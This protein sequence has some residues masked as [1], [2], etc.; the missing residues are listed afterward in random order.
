MGQFK[1]MV[2]METTEPSVILKLKKGGKVAPLH[3]D[4]DGHTNMKGDAFRAKYSEA[5]CEGDAPKKPSMA[6]RRK[7]MSGALLNSKKGGKAMKHDDAAQDRAMIKKAMA[8]KKF[9][10]G[11]K[12]TASMAKTTVKGNVGKFVNTDMETADR[13]T[14]AKGT[15]GVKNGNAGGYASGGTIKGNVGKFANTD[16]ETADRTTKAKGTGGVKNGNGGGYAGGGTIKGGSW[17]N[18]PADTAKAGKSGGTT[19]GVRNGNAGGYKTGG[20]AKKSYATGGNVVN[21][22]RAVAMPKKALS[23]PVSNSRQSGTF[24][25]GGKVKKF[26]MGGTTGA[27]VMATPMQSPMPAGY[28]S[29]APMPT[30]PAMATSPAPQFDSAQMDAMKQFMQSNGGKPAPILGGVPL[31][32]QQLPMGPN[33]SA[34]SQQDINQQAMMEAQKKAQMQSPMGGMRPP[35]GGSMGGMRGGFGG[36]GGGFG[37]M[38]PPMGGGFGGMRPQMGGGM[39]PPPNM[40][41]VPFTPAD[42]LA[43]EQK[44]KMAKFGVMDNIAPPP[45]KMVALPSQPMPGMGLGD[46]PYAYKRGGKVGR[47]RDGDSV[48]IDVIP[49][50]SSKMRKIANADTKKL[51]DDAGLPDESD[52]KMARAIRRFM[53]LEKEPAPTEKQSIHS[54]GFK[55]GGKAKR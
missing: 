25:M 42:Q 36:M 54:G 10:D 19:G 43:A 34:M 51:Y 20:A 24:K 26:A 33:G 15:G 13:T 3:Q 40:G 5:S 14:K 29:S 8:G 4:A 44:A 9:A 17:E 53:G 39:R 48:E 11:G 41:K 35:M 49:A 16:M 46:T 23:Q 18:R 38:R 2:K 50:T 1:P 21:D 37:N 31:Q 22:G 30:A 55:K 28:S 47:Y 32:Q 52:M 7:A 6:E 45:E 12:V 27:P